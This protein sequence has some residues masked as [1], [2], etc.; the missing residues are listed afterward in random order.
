MTIFT[1]GKAKT[2][3]LATFYDISAFKPAAGPTLQFL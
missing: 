3:I 2:D 1:S